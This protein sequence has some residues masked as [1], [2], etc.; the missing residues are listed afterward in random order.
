MLEQNQGP[1]PRNIHWHW[2]FLAHV[3]GMGIAMEFNLLQ[4]CHT[5][6]ADLTYLIL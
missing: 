5:D 1:A 2:V 4:P 3:T 6:T